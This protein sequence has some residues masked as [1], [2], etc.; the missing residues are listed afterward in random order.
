MTFIHKFNPLSGNIELIDD[1]SR[2][3]YVPYTGAAANVDLGAFTLTVT[4]IVVSGTVDGVDISA[5]S[6]SNQPT[7]ISDNVDFGDYDIISVATAYIDD[8]DLDGS[9]TMDA[10]ETVDGVD[11]SAISL[12]NQPAA[13][14]GD[15]DYGDYDLTSV[16]KLEGVDANT[17]IDLGTSGEIVI[18]NDIN[19][20]GPQGRLALVFDDA[21]SHLELQEGFFKVGPG[22]S[23]IAGGIVSYWPSP[24]LVTIGVLGYCD[25]TSSTGVFGR[26]T[27]YGVHGLV[28][29]AD[30]RAVYGKSD[31]NDGWA[32]YFDGGTNRGLY[33]EPNLG[34]NEAN[35]SEALDVVGNIELN[36]NMIIEDDG[37]IGCTG[38][39]TITFDTEHPSTGRTAIEYSAFDHIFSNYAT[40]DFAMALDLYSDTIT[41]TPRFIFSRSHSDTEGTNVT[42]VDNEIFGQIVA[43]GVDAQE[44][45]L[46][47][48]GAY[49]QFIQNGTIANDDTAVPTD[50]EFYTSPGGS[51]EPVLGMTLTKNRALDLLGPFTV[52]VSGTGHDVKF[53]GDTANYYALWDESADELKLR[54]AAATTLESP[55]ITFEAYKSGFGSGTTTGDI[56]ANRATIGGTNFFA[57]VSSEDIHISANSGAGD[58]V[59]DGAVAFD[60]DNALAFGSA[61]LGDRPFEIVFASGTGDVEFTPIA[62]GTAPGNPP[63]AIR[64]NKSN[65]DTDFIIEGN[66]SA[67][68]F[69]LNAVANNITINDAAVSANYDLMLAGDGVLGLKETATPTADTD[70]GKIYCKN[71]NKLYFQD[72]AG[73]EHEIE[74]GAGEEVDQEFTTTT[75]D[76]YLGDLSDTEYWE[77]Q[78]F[79]L[80][81]NKTVTA[82]ELYLNSVNGTPAGNWTIRIETDDG[83]DPSG[84]LADANATITDSAP[85]AASAKKYSFETPFA[86]L[87]STTYWIVVS[88]PAQATN[89]RWHTG[90][91]NTGGYASGNRAYSTDGAAS[92]THNAERDMYFKVYVE[93]A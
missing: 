42:T 43:E 4:S 13:I 39:P 91:S 17:Y 33:V 46:S 70:Y 37:T 3:G 25:T 83:G 87:G 93:T 19:I 82:V 56:Y 9:I 86:L 61:A 59:L 79:Q 51:T 30:G 8:I 21:H 58:I 35:P 20:T 10:N 18:P 74:M 47:A 44:T 73:V 40:N 65:V 38:G 63:D 48:T 54:G 75:D 77:G 88:C 28:D 57:I 52:G 11:P 85:E 41:D 78:S 12:N 72:G 22:A 60:N 36:G 90:G 80:S 29:A 27:L 49:I 23:A 53:W 71:D 14:T 55:H 84:V 67:N 89:D 50:I 92:W 15:V 34:I 68:C 32:G 1:V 76:Y 81:A 26:G 6:L 16:D 69:T 64:F 62:I 45:P 66:A 24:Q 2:T 7:A 31:H 5:I